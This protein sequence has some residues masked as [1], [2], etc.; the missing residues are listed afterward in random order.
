MKELPTPETPQK[1]QPIK[2]KLI[3]TKKKKVCFCCRA[4]G[5][6][7]YFMLGQASVFIYKEFNDLTMS[8][9]AL[10]YKGILE[11]KSS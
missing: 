7:C 1:R 4:H 10:V 3:D 8:Y 6:F 9:K 2:T 5:Q 11:T